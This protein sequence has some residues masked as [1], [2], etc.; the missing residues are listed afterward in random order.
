MNEKIY[1]IIVFH[2]FFPPQKVN[3][4]GLHEI[5]VLQSFKRY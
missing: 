4:Q 1:T 2:L 5:L 3:K